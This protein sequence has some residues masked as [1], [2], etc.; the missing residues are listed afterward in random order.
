M[1]RWKCTVKTPSGFFKTIHVEADN[2]LDATIQAEN[3]I[4]GDCTMVNLDNDLSRSS[5]SSS[6][7]SNSS[8]GFILL[9]IAGIVIFKFWQW[10]L[11]FLGIGF[12]I[13]AIIKSA[14]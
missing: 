11:L 7:S 3:M 9:I 4:G 14:E 2:R 8:G 12:I 10:A 1:Q 6:N 5:S 13:F